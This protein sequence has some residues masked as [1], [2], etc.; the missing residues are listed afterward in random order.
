MGTN[1]MMTY[2]GDGI[3]VVGLRSESLEGSLKISWI[4]NKTQEELL[5]QSRTR[6]R[7]RRRKERKKDQSD[8]I[9]LMQ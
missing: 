1:K 3:V 5:L 4:E 7:K 6:G 8:R 9:V 2:E